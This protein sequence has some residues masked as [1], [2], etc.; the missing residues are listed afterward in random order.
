M[1][2]HAGYQVGQATTGQRGVKLYRAQPF[3]S[4]SYRSL[5]PDKDGFGSYDEL[6]KDFPKVK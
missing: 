5:H 2:T 3:E 1:W 6:R 4:S